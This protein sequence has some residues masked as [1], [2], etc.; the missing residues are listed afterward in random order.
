[1]RILKPLG[2]ILFL[3]L[4]SLNIAGQGVDEFKERRKK[5][6]EKLPDKTIVILFSESE[7]R[8]AY[9]P[10]RYK[11]DSNFYYLSGY[12]KPDTAIMLSK[13][14]DAL[15]LKPGTIREAEKTE[16][17]EQLKK[18]TGFRMITTFNDFNRSFSYLLR[19]TEIIYTDLSDVN[20]DKPLTEKIIFCNRLKERFVNIRFKNV[21]DLIHNLRCIHS[22]SE[23][24]SMRKAMEIT[25]NAH[26]ELMKSVAPGLYEYELEAICEYVFKRQGAM[27]PAF[28]PIIGSGK[29]GIELHY[30]KNKDKLEKGDLVV[31]D[32]G[33]LYKMYGAD[34]TRTIPVSGKFT[35]RQKQFYNIVLKAQLAAIEVVKPGI[36]IREADQVAVNIMQQELENIG[37][38]KKGDKSAVYKYRKHSISHFLGLDTHDVGDIKGKLKPGM[39]ITIEPG[40]YI[41]EYGFGIR[42]E[43]DVLVTET[44][45][46]VLSKAPKTVSEIEKLIKKTGIGNH[47]ISNISALSD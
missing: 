23:L 1:M 3:V 15:I 39:V 25:D 16:R 38:I 13:Q 27:G 17:I 37:F 42:I 10:S 9:W 4:F 31:M 30:Q 32:I 2:A 12:S 41:P 33:A 40:I 35:E 21:S 5:I 34:I 36:L 20:L 45:H 11:P 43:D 6:Q 44:G 29:N 26:L 19:E 28:T 14:F 22:E 8:R 46:E 24:A 18:E 47:P 7:R